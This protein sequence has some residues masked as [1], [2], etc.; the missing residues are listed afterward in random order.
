MKP[1]LPTLDTEIRPND[2]G[3]LDELVAFGFVH[4]EQLDT[5]SWFMVIDTAD[6][7]GVRVNF[8]SKAALHSRAEDDGP[9]DLVPRVLRALRRR[10]TPLQVR[11]V[12]LR[13]TA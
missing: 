4:L 11:A 8:W 9:S 1:K 2:D 3:T 6:G 7:R 12:P 13:G 5:G 10:T